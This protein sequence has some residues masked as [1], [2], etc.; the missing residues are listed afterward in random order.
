MCPRELVAL[1][2]AALG[3]PLVNQLLSCSNPIG[4][5]SFFKLV[6]YITGF[7]VAQFSRNG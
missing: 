1:A 6:G 2:Q 5:D 4:V 7:L 3:K